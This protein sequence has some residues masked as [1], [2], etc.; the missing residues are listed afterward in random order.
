[1]RLAVFIDR[2][3][4]RSRRLPFLMELTSKRLE[5]GGVIQDDLDVT[6]DRDDRVGHA[7]HKTG[8]PLMLQAFVIGLGRF[9][10]R[11]RFG[12]H[13]A[14]HYGIS[15]TAALSSAG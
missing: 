9:Y 15:G 10:H 14:Y 13:T 1:M 7:V 5:R 6:V 11:F 8:E 2:R 12:R 3:E 4:Q